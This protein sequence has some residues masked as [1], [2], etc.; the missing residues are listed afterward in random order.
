MNNCTYRAVVINA[1]HVAGHVTGHV[2]GHEV[3][4]HGAR[5]VAGVAGHLSVFVLSVERAPDDAANGGHGKYGNGEEQ[6]HLG[7]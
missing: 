1:L 5:H 2:A 4:G 6:L 7:G 3:A